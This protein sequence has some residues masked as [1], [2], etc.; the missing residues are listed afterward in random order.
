MYRKG[1]TLFSDVCYTTNNDI[2]SRNICLPLKCKHY[3]IEESCVMV[4]SKSIMA[5]ANNLTS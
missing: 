2:N 3:Y 5:K 1:I 4:V